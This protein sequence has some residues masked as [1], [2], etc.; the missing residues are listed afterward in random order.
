MK[1]LIIEDRLD[2][3]DAV[4]AQIKS[5]DRDPIID[6]VKNLEDAR[7]AILTNLYDLIVF[8]IF[9]PLRENEDE[10]NVADDLIRT[11]SQSKNYQAE[12]IALT[13]FAEEGLLRAQFNDHG[14]TVVSYD[15]QGN[16][17]RS[18]AQKFIRLSVKPRS[19]FLI[20]C[21][22]SKERAA[23]QNTD[24]NL[25]E[26]SEIAGLNCQEMGIDGYR[27]FCITPRRMGLVNMA[28]TVAKAIEIFQPKMVAMSGICAGIEGETNLLD[29]VVGDICWEY[30]TGKFKN[31]QFLQEPYQV[32]ISSEIRVNIEQ[33]IEE[34]G[35]L[36]SIKIG[37]YNTELQHST[38]HLGPISSGSAVIAD[39][40]K[41]LEIG[42]QHR[43]W[44][45][46]E[47]EMYA[48]YEAAAQSQC[49]PV[50]FGAKSVVD[51]GSSAKGDALH[52]SA[53]VLSARFAT[54]VLQKYL[55][56]FAKNN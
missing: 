9:L 10:Q 34:K 56:K 1:Y 38:L 45:G 23:F 47:M 55:P 18:L 11:F 27:G 32:P 22:L 43:K 51:M 40:S 52:A 14:I 48:F 53:C 4:E 13:L 39:Q 30:Q 41:M 24:A 25:L 36:D 44:A 21:A 50:Y 7:V 8:D 16:W 15:D 29:I 2:K 33:M 6:S 3:H 19:D 20:F 35:F 12:S 49:R 37:L 26:L 46:L 42:L 5:L 54:K 31:N 17:K 28:L